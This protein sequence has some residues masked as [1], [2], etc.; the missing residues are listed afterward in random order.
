M[1]FDR[2]GRLRNGTLRNAYRTAH[3]VIHQAGDGGFQG[4]REAQRLAIARQ[5]RDDATDGRQ[6]AHVEH[7]IGFV[8]NQGLHRFEANQPAAK[9]IF[10]PSRRGYD[11]PRSGAQGLNLRLLGQTADNEGCGR[12]FLVAQLF[13]L[14]VNL[15]G[16]FARGHQDKRFRVARRSLQQALDQGHQERQGFASAGLGGGQDVSARKS[17]RDRFRLNGGGNSEISKRQLPLKISGKRH[18]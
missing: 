3:V 12:K 8:E 7:A 18:F 14:F 1:E 13:V 9:E 15:H 10:Q 11:D 16:K 6:K 4:C 17:V 2:V 5:H